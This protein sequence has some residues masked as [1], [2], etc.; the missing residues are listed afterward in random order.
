[1][2]TPVISCAS[3]GLNSEHGSI[4]ALGDCGCVSLLPEVADAGVGAAGF[5]LPVKDELLQDT[6]SSE[7]SN[8]ATQKTFFIKGLR[9]KFQIVNE[10]TRR[11]AMLFGLPHLRFVSSQT[12]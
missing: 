11:F 4:C 8:A 3:A 5:E 2:G 6:G 9:N 10:S 1:M 7:N 12:N